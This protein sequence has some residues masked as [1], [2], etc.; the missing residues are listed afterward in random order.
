MGE[1]WHENPHLWEAIDDCIRVSNKPLKDALDI[2]YE[3]QDQIHPIAKTVIYGGL[4]TFVSNYAKYRNN[5][6]PPN[7]SFGEAL[8]AVQSH[9]LMVQMFAQGIENT[10]DEKVEGMKNE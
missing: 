7:V 5:T 3:Y 1:A 2:L 6:N 8:K 10:I 9:P 4:A